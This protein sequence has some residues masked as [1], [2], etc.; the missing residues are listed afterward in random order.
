MTIWTTVKTAVKITFR[1]TNRM[2][3]LL[4]RHT[5][6]TTGTS[7]TIKI[8]TRTGFKLELVVLESVVESR[9]EN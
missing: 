8:K 6:R 2:L 7:I 9:W 3:D 4:I 5:I 1:T